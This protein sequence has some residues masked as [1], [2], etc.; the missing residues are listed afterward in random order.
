[1]Q[2]LKYIGPGL[3]LSAAGFAGWMSYSNGLRGSNGCTPYNTPFDA[4]HA[5]MSA[6]Q[7]AAPFVVM[8]IAGHLALLF[9]RHW[10]P[11]WFTV[12]AC[13]SLLALA[14]TTA[15]DS[16]LRAYAPCDYKGDEMSFFVF[17]MAVLLVALWLFI[18]FP[19]VIIAATQR[20]HDAHPT[21]R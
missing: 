16:H 6:L 7:L 19:L 13:A 20:L 11:R 8:A 15:I 17:L 10:F 12:L 3:A 5:V 2:L 1:M 21:E 9:F 18:T 4:Q 14:A